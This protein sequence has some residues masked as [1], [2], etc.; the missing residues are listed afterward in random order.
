M[1]RDR[2][3]G[4]KPNTAQKRKSALAGSLLFNK[5]GGEQ[6]HAQCTKPQQALKV[7]V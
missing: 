6:K 2:S 3:V 4:T 5:N 7:W 1:G